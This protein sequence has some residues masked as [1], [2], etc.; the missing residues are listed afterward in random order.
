MEDRVFFGLFPSYERLMSPD[1]KFVAGELPLSSFPQAFITCAVYVLSVFAL[2]AYMKNREPVTADWLR[3]FSIAHN[4][5]LFVLS[6]AMLTLV[7]F[8]IGLIWY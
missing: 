4:V 8:E 5:F 7:S 2:K 6:A 1:F 3:K